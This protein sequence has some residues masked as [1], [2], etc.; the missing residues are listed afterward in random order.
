MGL[1]DDFRLARLVQALALQI[2]NLIEYKELSQI[3]GM[4]F[5]TVKKYCNFLTKTFVCQFVK[6]FKTNKRSQLVK[7]PK[8]F[9]MDS[10]LRNYIVN[11]FRGLDGRTDDGSLLENTVASQ[12]SKQ[13]LEPNYWR[14]KK[15]HEMD[16]VV[17]LP[18]REKI[19]ME[20]KKTFRPEDINS[21]SSREFQKLYPEIRLL[22][23]YLQSKNFSS[24]QTGWPIYFI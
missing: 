3:S 20:V 11:D 12:I 7:N 19:A 8:V 4:S 22:P 6:P 21:K 23:L 24:A 2:G 10:G 13:G 5:L 9:F 15:G 14:T 17:D 1:I 16:F 18:G